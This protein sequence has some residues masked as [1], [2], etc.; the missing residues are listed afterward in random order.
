MWLFSLVAS[1][2]LRSPCIPSAP[3]ALTREISTDSAKIYSRICFPKLEAPSKYN[4]NLYYQPFELWFLVLKSPMLHSLVT[5]NSTDSYHLILNFPNYQ[6]NHSSRHTRLYKALVAKHRRAA[7]SDYQRYPTSPIP[8]FLRYFSAFN[9]AL[10]CLDLRLCI[11]WVRRLSHP[12][13]IAR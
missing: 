9:S 12:S 7:S 10:V 13:R 8:M 4:Q 5:L 2:H 3:R 1:S 6:T 11:Q